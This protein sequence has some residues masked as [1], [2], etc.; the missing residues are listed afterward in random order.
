MNLC[1][2]LEN[3]RVEKYRRK[4]GDGEEGSGDT[5]SQMRGE[6]SDI[7]EVV[8]AIDISFQN[9]LANCV[10]TSLDSQLI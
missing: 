4:V 5:F 2:T 6:R 8:M 7:F 1:T 3:H 10:I 9:L